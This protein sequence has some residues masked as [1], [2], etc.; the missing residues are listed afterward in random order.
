MMSERKH[1][2]ETILAAARQ[3]SRASDRDAYLTAACAQDAALRAE[4]EQLLLHADGAETLVQEGWDKT[5][6]DP[7]LGARLG[8]YQIQS[9]LGQ[10]GMGAVY[11]AERADGAFRQRVAIK[12]V[13]RGM[14]TNFILRRFR[15]ERQILATLNHPFIARLLD[16]GTTDDGLPYFVMEFIE[17]QMLYRYSD[18]KRL[19]VPER[20]QLFLQV[21]EAVEY[22]HQNQVIHRDLKPSNVLVNAEHVPKLLDFGIAKVLN[23]EMASDTV[24]P[25]AT[26]MR[27]MTPDYASP[28]QIKGEMVSAASDIYSL[29]V[30]LYELLTGH[31]PYRFRHRAPHEISR[32]VCEDEPEIPSDSLARQDNFAPTGSGDIPTTASILAARNAT[33][34]SLRRTLSGDLD[35]I[36]LKALR[37]NPLE[38]YA[39]VAA[40][41]QDIT[42]FLEKRPVQAESFA[43]LKPHARSTISATPPQKH[44]VAI[45]PLHVIG[46]SSNED[47]GEMY[48]GIGLADA[49]ILRLSQ[50]PRFIM[51]PTSSVLRYQNAAHD[52]F[53]AGRELDVEFIVEGTIRRAGERIRVTVRLLDT[54][55]H[56]TRWAEHFDEK[57]TDVLALEDSIS[58]RIAHSLVP[59]LTGEEAQKISKRGTNN[60]QAYETY[61]RGRYFYNQFS[62]EGL[63]KAV[64]AFREAIALDPNYAMPHVGMADFY[65]WAAIFGAMPSSEAFPLAKA[66]ARRA[67]EIDDQLGEAYAL[68]AFAALLFDWDW[69]ES[70]RLVKRALEL[71]PNNS[72]AHECYSNWFASQRRFPEAIQSIRRAEELEPLS[73]RAMLMTAWTLYQA[74]H[75]DEALAKAQQANALRVDFPQGLLHL[76]NNLT[77]AGRAAEAVSVLRRSCELWDTFGLPQ[78]M[79]VCAHIK[80]GQRTEALQTLAEMKARAA[81]SYVKPYFLAA[82]CAAVGEF[83]EAFQWFEKAVAEHSE[84]MIWLATDSNLDRLRQDARYLALLRRTNNPIAQS[85]QTDANIRGGDK[86]L[87]VL[88]FKLLNPNVDDAS[89]DF[90]GV[91]LADALIT[92]LSTVRRFIVR[93][94]S[95]VLRFGTTS[96]SLQAGRDLN[97]DYVLTGNI[98]RLTDRIRVTTQLLS[99]QDE[100]ARWAGSFDEN[101][102]DVLEL[103]DSISARVAKALIPHLTGEEQK[104]L[105]KRGT[106]KPEAYEA[107]LRGRYYW[108]QFTPESLPKAHAAFE[109]AIALDPGYALAYVGLGDFYIWA[110]IYGLMPSLPAQEKAE[111]L[112]RRAM[113]LDE[114]LGE[115]YST[116]G[117]ILQNQ[118]RWEESEAVTKR[119]IQLSP[120]YIH[121]HEWY[122]AILVGTGRTEEGIAEMRLTERLDPLSPRTKT[123]VAWTLYQAH[124]FAEALECAQQIV[125]L[126]KNYP[127]AYLQIGLNLLALGR[128]VEALP[129]VQKFDAMIPD[130]ALAKYQLCFAYVAAGQFDAARN[131]FAQIKALA[132]RGHVKPYFLAMAHAAFGEYDAAFRYF[133]QA[134]AENEAWMLWFGTEPMLAGLHDDARFVRLLEKMQNPIVE[135]YYSEASR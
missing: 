129:M 112:A 79:L 55:T 133:E 71:S 47:T 14:D 45:L 28:E 29:G 6:K 77:H 96:D 95:S 120:N 50:V 88:P 64:A 23:S 99:V 65:I 90:M 19:S 48:L 41:A 18:D 46:A 1:L 15:Q 122:G 102:A 42:S 68:L 72:F 31:R 51:R 33:L 84:W 93:P 49:L 56:T 54:K 5:L 11:L 38:R 100:A 70:E 123:L 67:L 17:G 117:L 81:R 25:T 91:G 22:A 78:H 98:R 63:Q 9:E 92:R 82:A 7:L 107:Y 121:A 73:P 94:T 124:R 30:L 37:K 127:Q 75:Y 108:N 21:C 24:D 32:A 76:G 3:L 105:A 34:T 80:N 132:E 135:K 59:Q 118:K 97:V 10:G 128:P 115:A 12:L 58:E 62:D 101:S 27:L 125:D 89:G 104:Q 85:R 8:A 69:A 119:A 40:L 134:L 13:K 60:P 86:S 103:E 131:V 130:S 87:A 113:A 2:L 16:G 53:A 111:Q 83:D 106:N 35:R 74:R 52:P 110:S 57:F 44:S 20:L 109:S 126:D 114:E 43:A 36:I 66:E 4:V 116:L 26:H 39:S 61:L